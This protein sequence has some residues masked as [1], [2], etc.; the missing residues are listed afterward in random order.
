M[1]PLVSICIAGRRLHVSYIDDKI[2]VTATCIHLYPDTSCSSGILV[3]GYMIV[4]GVN[5][6]L[7][8]HQS[9]PHDHV[10]GMPRGVPYLFT[11][12]QLSPILITVVP[13][14]IL[15]SH[16]CIHR[17]LYICGLVH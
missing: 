11:A 2:V 17:G 13:T 5:A 12:Q 10:H 4:S 1:Y 6:T 8:A 16:K 15:G 14:G 7:V 9:K 3:S